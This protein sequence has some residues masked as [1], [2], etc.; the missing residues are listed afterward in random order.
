MPRRSNEF[1][2]LVFLLQNQL[3]D[4]AATVVESAMVVDWNTGSEVEVDIVVR[5]VANDVQLRLGFEC[6]AE[7][8]PATVEWIREM[9]GKHSSLPI[10][11]TILVAKRGFTKEAKQFAESKS[12][13]T[14]TLDEAISA[15]W[16]T[17]LTAM[18]NLRIGSITFSPVDFTARVQKRPGETVATQLETRV[19]WPS[20]GREATI[21]EYWS[22]LLHR[23]DLLPQVMRNWLATPTSDRKNQF[24]FTLTVTPDPEMEIAT[25]NGQWRIVE[26]ASTRVNASVQDVPLDLARGKLGTVEFAFARVP[27]VFA[28]GGSDYAIVSLLSGGDQP[29]KAAI[30]FPQSASGSA[31]VHHME[32]A[33]QVGN[34][35]TDA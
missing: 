14:L 16:A 21:Q 9:W 8:R 5:L 23:K 24:G 22:S 26:L 11:K 27:N 17:W 13:V 20:L 18:S 30:L 3:A 28:H 32:I 19:R 29:G 25:T 6:T 12:M 31:T 35:A 7:A 33:N 10:D 1:Q 2:R 34:N 4:P 15:S